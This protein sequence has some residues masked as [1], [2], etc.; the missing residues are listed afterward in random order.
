MFLFLIVI[1]LFQYQDRN[2]KELCTWLV[3]N[4]HFLT[5]RNSF[6][7]TFPPISNDHTTHELFTDTL[8]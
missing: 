1:A 4:L 2:F 5:F 3:D 7:I 8:T 6:H